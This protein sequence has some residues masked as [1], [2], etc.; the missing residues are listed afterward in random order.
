MTHTENYYLFR[1]CIYQQLRNTSMLTA[2]DM[3]RKKNA[4]VII[5]CY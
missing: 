4:L 1:F 3:E 5:V 2:D